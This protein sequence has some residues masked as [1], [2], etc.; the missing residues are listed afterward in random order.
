M[1]KVIAFVKGNLVFLILLASILYGNQRFDRY[2]IR[3]GSMEPELQTGAIVAADSRRAPEKG[4][5]GVYFSNG[6]AVIHRVIDITED[7]YWFQGD[8]NPEPD[9]VC[10]MK[11]DVKGTVVFRLNASAPI[12]R[13]VFRLS[14]MG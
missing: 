1:K 9:A 11:K 2:L 8:A 4:E 13:G 12:L 5:I 3:T 7:G 6:N 14:K 10:I